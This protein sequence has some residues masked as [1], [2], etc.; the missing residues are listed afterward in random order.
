MTLGMAGRLSAVT[1]AALCVAAV[2]GA[3]PQTES[4]TRPASSREDRVAAEEA[5]RQALAEARRLLQTGRL[6]EAQTLIRP[7]LQR[8]AE[9]EGQD[10]TLEGAVVEVLAEA[11]H[12]SGNDMQ[13]E[14][15]PQLE[16]LMELQQQALGAHHPAL[17]QVLLE[18]A[19]LSYTWAGSDEAER[20]YRRVVSIQLASPQIDPLAA[21]RTQIY[22]ATLLNET[23]APGRAKL[24]MQEALEIAQQ[25]LGSVAELLE[26]Q[27]LQ[28]RH[29]VVAEALSDLGVALYRI[30]DLA[31]ARQLLEQATVLFARSLGTG[32]PMAAVVEFNRAK[33]I[34]RLGLPRAAL[35]MLQ[36]VL[37]IWRAALGEKHYSVGVA[38]L[39]V[40]RLLQNLGRLGEARDH[41]L[42]AYSN[43]EA[44]LA[45]MVTD[46]AA[47]THSSPS[48]LKAPATSSAPGA[49]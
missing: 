49:K 32:H 30:G 24:A 41:L 35:A 3:T 26:R 45:S 37:Q 27:Q 2:A 22:L 14:D 8:A 29:A 47:W 10:I 19:C 43:L 16:H 6:S 31:E 36:N 46:P 34:E 25:E 48:W 17:E 5:V 7:M 38:H 1:L 42:A 40:G 11:L 20:L 28:Q 12:R 44:S 9:L 13:P 18:L 4:I 21:A 39:Q 23:G 33:V 15:R